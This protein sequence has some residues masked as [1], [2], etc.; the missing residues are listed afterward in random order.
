MIEVRAATDADKGGI[1]LLLTEV[2]GAAHAARIERLWQWQWHDDPRLPEPGYRGAVAVHDGQIFGTASFIPAA[3][4]MKGEMM[5]A[6][7]AVD[8][9]VHFPWLR[10][11]IRQQRA[12]SERVSRPVGGIAAKLLDLGGPVVLCKHVGSEMRAIC[13][14]NGF[15]PMPESGY[16]GRRFGLTARVGRAFGSSVAPW[17]RRL[18]DLSLARIGRPPASVQSHQG[19][20]DKRFDT[21]WA[22]WLNSPGALGLR[23]AATLNWRYHRHPLTRY[24]F[25]TD[26]VDTELRGYAVVTTAANGKGRIVDL[27][28]RRGHDDL[29]TGLLRGALVELRRSGADRADCYLANARWQRYFEVVGMHR[30][31]R[32]V[33]LIVRGVD[34]GALAFATA[35]DGDSG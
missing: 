8:V 18:P 23:D 31:A 25:V 13:Y 19:L 33:P 24:A 29:V 16:F 5:T 2:F 32:N 35:G 17:V 12:S 1:L 26:V 27:L 4:R 9:A 21:L 34:S 6:V 30:T 28:V 22:S 15:V 11:A 14:K 7:W 20:C 10:R 3:L